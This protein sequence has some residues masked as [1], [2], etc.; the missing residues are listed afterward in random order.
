M[1]QFRA[2]VE[3]LPPS[4]G[5]IRVVAGPVAEIVI[6]HPPTRNALTP[7]MMVALADAIGAVSTAR[8]VILRGEGNAFC[9]GGNLDA[10]RTHLFA[11]GTGRALG[12]FMHR[13]VNDL[14][15][16]DAPVI[17]V[18][19]GPALGGGAELLTGCDFVYA[20]P[21][22]RIGFIQARLGVAPGFGGGTRL[23]RR[24]GPRL[25]LQLLTE[26][27]PVPA[28][29]CPLVDRVDPDPLVAARERAAAL[30]RIPETALSAAKRIVVAAANQ[31][32][33]AAM[34]HELDEFAAL[35]GGPAHRAA[36]KDR[37]R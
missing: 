3:A 27:E 10:V 37:S 5:R 1:S 29:A 33:S 20:S 32:Q 26:S 28:A 15:A 7:R 8:V 11:E 14:A 22:A 4:E 34:A 25:A 9:S 2:W 12:A 23:T 31:S 17:A 18:V 16:L 6:D 24:L 35:W 19:E 36:L 30:L 21:S 13:A